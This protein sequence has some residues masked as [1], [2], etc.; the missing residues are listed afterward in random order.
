MVKTVI[1][2]AKGLVQSAGSGATI[3][4]LNMGAVT[5]SA[6]GPSTPD[7]SEANVVIC[8]TSGTTVTL[9]GLSG[10]RIGQVV[11]IVKSSASNNLV[12]EHAEGDD[13][14]FTNPSGGDLTLTA[15]ANVLMCVYDG[16]SWIVSDPS[17]KS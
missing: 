5:V 9:G 7:V 15:V 4:G 11:H 16:A 17:D 10:G 6:A 14:D 8:N 3:K 1:D 12:L 13:Q 2:N